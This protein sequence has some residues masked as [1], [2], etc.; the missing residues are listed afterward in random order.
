MHLEGTYMILSISTPIC[1]HSVIDTVPAMIRINIDLTDANVNM[2]PP[3]FA[4]SGQPINA[5][6]LCIASFGEIIFCPVDNGVQ[7]ISTEKGKTIECVYLHPNFDKVSHRTLV[8][9]T[10]EGKKSLLSR[11]IKSSQVQ[12]FISLSIVAR[13]N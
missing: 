10:I 11:S 5:K 7:H 8:I 4:I 9:D 2:C 13:I 6:M 3:L 1:C 12:P